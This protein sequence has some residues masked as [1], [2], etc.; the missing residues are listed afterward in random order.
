MLEYRI[1]VSFNISF[2]SKS[3]SFREPL[4]KFIRRSDAK[5]VRVY[6][7]LLTNGE[8][9]W[10]LKVVQHVFSD[11]LV[12]LYH[13][14]G[15]LFSLEV[16]VQET[17]AAADLTVFSISDKLLNRNCEFLSVHENRQIMVS[18]AELEKVNELH[19]NNNVCNLQLISRY[20]I[21]QRRK[22]SYG[23]EWLCC[24]KGKSKSGAT[25]FILEVR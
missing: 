3:I 21:I 20:F 8:I 10:K 16:I 2:A 17:F 23:Y 1:V 13:L 19:M 18:L 11:V 24:L 25:T 4:F 9:F 6:L 7:H 22:W 15:I 5:Y 14:A 12:F